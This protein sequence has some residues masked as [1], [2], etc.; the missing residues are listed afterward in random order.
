MDE[1]RNLG[2]E[3]GGQRFRQLAA[4]LDPGAEGAECAR[5]LRESEVLPD[6]PEGAFYLFPDFEP[7]RDT[8]RDRSIETSSEL[9]RRLLQEAGVAMLP[10]S[11]FGR[12]KDEMRAR[13]AYVDFDGASA[14][15]AAESVPLDRPLPVQFLEDQCGPVLR[16]IRLIKDWLVP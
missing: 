2:G 8:L 11:D 9:C 10:G 13:L 14:L 12:P 16:A 3:T 15:V 5:R 6:E 7:H 4:V 1:R